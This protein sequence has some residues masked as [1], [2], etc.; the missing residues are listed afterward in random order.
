M[1]YIGNNSKWGMPFEPFNQKFMNLLEN[2]WQ[3]I[4]NIDRNLSILI[5]LLIILESKTRFYQ[6]LE[7]YS[8]IDPSTEFENHS[9]IKFLTG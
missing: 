1:K 8:K 3:N 5:Y 6:V 7:I 4:D 9:V 2:K